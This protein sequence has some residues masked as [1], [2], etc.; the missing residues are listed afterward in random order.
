MEHTPG[1]WHVDDEHGSLVIRN[2]GLVADIGP[3]NKEANAKLIAASPRL[4]DALRD[5]IQWAD[6]VI[7]EPDKAM[8]E[9]TYG[10]KVI[11]A[12]VAAIEAAS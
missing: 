3:A 11:K 8:G 1:P 2:G 6:A 12:A 7:G 5:L 4:L 10:N 9:Q